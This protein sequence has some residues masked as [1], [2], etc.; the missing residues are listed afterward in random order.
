VVPLF[1]LE[2]KFKFSQAIKN[3]YV[4]GPWPSQ[5]TCNNFQ[6]SRPSNWI[7]P[8][9]MF[10]F[11][12][13]PRYSNFH[14]EGS[15]NRNWA[16]DIREELGLRP[17]LWGRSNESF[18]HPSKKWNIFSRTNMFSDRLRDSYHLCMFWLLTGLFLELWCVSWLVQKKVLLTRQKK[19]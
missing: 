12:P 9:R 5:P 19:N 2:N 11:P 17:F 3:N 1:N 15:S 7:Q 16:F 14:Q 13:R 8:T 6:V 18:F 10:Q 4:N